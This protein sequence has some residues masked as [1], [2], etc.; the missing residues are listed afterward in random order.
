MPA[1]HLATLALWDLT[2]NM[3]KIPLTWNLPSNVLK[4]ILNIKS[5]LSWHAS[6]ASLTRPVGNSA[7]CIELVNP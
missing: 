4:R 1:R 3:H 7:S 6:R 5:L 2:R